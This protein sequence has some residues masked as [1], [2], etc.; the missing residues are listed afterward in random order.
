MARNSQ[1]GLPGS[2]F[3]SASFSSLSSAC[4]C[5]L[6]SLFFFN[7]STS[8]TTL[9]RLPRPFSTWA[10]CC[11]CCCCCCCCCCCACFC[12]LFCTGV[13]R[14]CVTAVVGVG[15]I[16]SS[17]RRP[18]RPETDSPWPFTD[19]VDDIMFVGRP[20]GRDSCLFEP[21]EILVWGLMVPA[22]SSLPLAIE[23]TTS[24]D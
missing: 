7:L 17:S 14:H 23:L 13:I 21:A 1:F 9:D 20:V 22:L 6:S 24:K 8:L 12:C 4:R 3:I 19:V 10:C 15:G 16:F 11:S 5:L 2:R 18:V